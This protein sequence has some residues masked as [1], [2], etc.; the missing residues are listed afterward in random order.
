MRRTIEYVS[1]RMVTRP[2]V[3]RNSIGYGWFMLPGTPGGMQFATCE[4]KL[5]PAR[6]L[7]A[8]WNA[9][10]F[11]AYSGVNCGRLGGGGG[12]G[13]VAL[14]AAAP[15][16][17]AAGAGGRAAMRAGSHTPEKSGRFASSAYLFPVAGAALSGAPCAFA[18][19]AALPL[20]PQIDP[21]TSNA[22]AS[23][24]GVLVRFILSPLSPLR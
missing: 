21:A 2:G 12:G 9:A 11:F 5:M 4:T 19:S 23:V 14:P 7:L 20:H 1:M 17:P 22:V 18:W 8:S 13:G 3:N 10:N 15:V 24:A 16:D 6:P